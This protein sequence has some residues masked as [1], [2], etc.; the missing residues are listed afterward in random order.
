MCQFGFIE[1]LK[2]PFELPPPLSFSFILV[3]EA[4]ARKGGEFREHLESNFITILPL[5][6]SLGSLTAVVHAGLDSE[7]FAP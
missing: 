7:L 4:A 6:K 1:G 2:L 3:R 5:P